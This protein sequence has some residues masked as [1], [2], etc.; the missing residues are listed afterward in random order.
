MCGIAGY[1]LRNPEQFAPKDL[2]DLADALMWM[3][4]SRG[5]HATGMVSVGEDVI[6]LQK[7]ACRAPEFSRGRRA[8]PEGV[9]TVLTH[10]R[11]ATQ[12]HQSFPE[13][14]HPV[15]CDSVYVT[16]NGHIVNDD[17]VFEGLGNPERMGD[18]DSEAIAVALAH[19]DW[20]LDGAKEALET[21]R[22]GF[23]IAAINSQHPKNLLLAKGP[24]SPLVVL[25]RPNLIV[26][27]S[28]RIAIEDAWKVVFGTPPKKGYDYLREGDLWAVSE[29]GSILKRT[30][31]VS[32]PPV[33]VAYARREPWASKES[34]KGKHTGDTT[35][36]DDLPPWAQVS[37]TEETAD[38]FC[39]IN[40]Y[41]KDRIAKAYYVAT[42]TESGM[43]VFT[44]SHTEYMDVDGNVT[45]SYRYGNPPTK[46]QTTTPEVAGSS[47]KQIGPPVNEIEAF[48]CGVEI[49]DGE[50]TESEALTV[51]DENG[52]KAGEVVY[53]GQTLVQCTDC[54]SYD[55]PFEMYYYSEAD[56]FYCMDCVEH[57]KFYGIN[58]ELEKGGPS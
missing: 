34:K 38:G 55:S 41:S 25:E 57:L 22:G 9:N 4:D 24:N 27:A 56:E 23:A 45:E 49:V 36:K 39:T 53:M 28:T 37:D 13:N 14:N 33:T 52:D 48:A 20:T 17:D 44:F 46:T 3:I 50:Y 29:D 11:F 32:R 54:S 19:R 51:Y 26:W 18:V 21:L 10:T 47:T 43:K 40:Q 16:H 31:Q 2:E 30:F 6:R 8:L 7:A 12:G 15:V 1:Y 42:T 35:T 5:G 58:L